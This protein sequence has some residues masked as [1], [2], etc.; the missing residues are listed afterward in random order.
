[1]A[2]RETIMSS[3]PPGLAP[4]GVERKRKARKP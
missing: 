3:E 1:M 2:S 4:D